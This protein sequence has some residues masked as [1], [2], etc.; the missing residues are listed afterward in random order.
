MAKRARPPKLPPRIAWERRQAIWRHNAFGG[1]T[2]FAENGLSGILTAGTTTQAARAK[3]AEVIKGLQELR[4]LL[5]KRELW[6]EVQ[7]D[8]K[9]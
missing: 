4:A 1:T 9:T 5:A 2:R 6:P 7:S 3:A 8:S